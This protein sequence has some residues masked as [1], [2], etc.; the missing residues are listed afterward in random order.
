[1]T[2][3]AAALFV[4]AALAVPGEPRACIRP[5]DTPGQRMAEGRWITVA[6][7][8]VVEVESRAPERPNRA[9]DAT[10]KIDR[11]VEGHPQTGRLELR[12]EEHTECPVVRPLPVTGE[13]WVVYLEWD[14]RGDGPV[15]EAWPLRWS[16][17]LDPRFGGRADADTTDLQPPHR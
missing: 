11:T 9:F 5:I 14:A 12:H 10:F 8:T 17:R 2:R 7:A 16:Q 6:V 4:L 1:M 13:S 15:T 3:I